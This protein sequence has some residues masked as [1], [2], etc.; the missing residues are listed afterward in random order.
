MKRNSL[1]ASSAVVLVG[2]IA[3]SGCGSRE[4]GTGTPGANPEAAPSKVQEQAAVKPVRL[5]LLAS[6]AYLY[7]DDFR[8]LV[9]EPLKKKY[10]HLTVDLVRPGHANSG[11]DRRQVG[12]RS[13][14]PV[15][16]KQGSVQRAGTYNQHF[17]D[18]EKTR[19]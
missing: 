11:P 17:A 19:D 9:T 4:G 7:D 16:S 10:P 8:L 6:E 3:L 13:D 14:H 12:T 1:L 5:T 2:A 15:E 18:S